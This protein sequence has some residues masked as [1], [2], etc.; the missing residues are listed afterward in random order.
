MKTIGKIICVLVVIVVLA[1]VGLL[2]WVKSTLPDYAGSYEVEGISGKIEIIRDTY[3]IPHIFAEHQ[4]DLAF[5]AGYAMG[6]DR[7]WQMDIFK[8]VSE[9]RLSE[10]FGKDALEA[11]RLARVL[12]FAR[13]ADV[14]VAALTQEEKEY[15]DSFLGGLNR[16]IETRPNEHPVEFRILGYKPEPFTAKDLLSILIY[17][18]F[19]NNFN[20]KLEL[21]RALAISELGKDQGR[22]LVPS[23]TFHGPYLTRPGEH[24][25]LEGIPGKR[26]HTDG[27]DALS[28]VSIS[29]ITVTAL[30]DADRLLTKYSG[31]PSG[32]VHSNCWAIS[33]DLT[34]SGKP[35]LVNDYHMPLLVPSLWYELHLSGDGIDAMGITL[36]GFP[37]IVAGHNRFIAWGATTDGADTQDIFLEKLNPENPDEY[38]YQG[39][40]EPFET[41]I[42]R[43]SVKEGK[44]L[45]VHEEKILIS[46]HGPII[47]GIVKGFEKEGPLALRTVSGS[48]TGTITFAIKMMRAKNWD[49]FKGALSH[50]NAFIWNWVYADRDGNIGF[51]VNGMIPIRASG[52][53]L[54]PV[55]GWEGKYEWAG[56]IPFAEL[57]E[58]Y[59]PKSGYLV[60]ANNEISDNSSP[61]IQ[62]GAF[63]LPYRAIRIEELIKAGRPLTVDT[64]RSIQADVQSKFGL[65]IARCVT[66]A[67]ESSGKGDA[68]AKELADLLSKWDG[69]ADSTPAG[70]AITNEVFVRLTDHLLKS[71]VSDDLYRLLKEEMY[72]TSG[73]ILLMLT[74][75][76]YVGCFDDPKTAQ[77]EGKDEL[78][79]KCLIEADASLTGY[80]GTEDVDRWRWGKLHTFT[81]AHPLGVVPPFKWLWNRGPFP[82]SGDVST[83]N[84]GYFNNI[85]EKPYRVTEGASMRHVIDF[86]DFGG[87]RFVISTGESERWLSPH[88]DD[89]LKLWLNVET[90]PMWMDR[91]A[92]EKNATG[93][94][95]LTPKK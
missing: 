32:L 41:V 39:K 21:T 88:Y 29:P 65:A 20:W 89:Q 5:G 33:G 92:I 71:R 81:F 95:K 61:S 70:P 75:K 79:V 49:D 30:L 60:T 42:E 12:G 59:N 84:P 22:A 50:Y 16:F 48:A 85:D 10:L 47:N 66:T 51:K 14:A 26:E 34:K 35:M 19:M 6:Q 38:L 76:S 64:A 4:N 40:Y 69:T 91:D 68:R 15:L 27:A 77:V 54:M 55:P 86:G 74:D 80:F 56:T 57:P 7:L 11:D 90:H 24:S 9:G 8:R 45:T 53:G 43:I 44:A 3:G 25:P 13:D 82:Y 23:L 94:L 28:S 93:I 17:Q 87:A 72:W 78:I 36:P 18:S 67:V 58:V 52:D 31:L 62:G 83:V 37:G 1:V 73:L 46:R 2:L 63:V